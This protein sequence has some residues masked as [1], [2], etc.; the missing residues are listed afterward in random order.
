MEAG[1]E[2]CQRNGLEY[3][4]FN[5]KQSLMIVGGVHFIF[6]LDES[7]SMKGKK[8]LDLMKAFEKTLSDIIKFSQKNQKNKVSVINF[9]KS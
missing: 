3:V 6:A 2:Y 7:T 5:K 4:D 9:A 1:P 8:W